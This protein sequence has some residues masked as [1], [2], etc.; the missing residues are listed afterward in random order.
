[1]ER[2]RGGEVE[3]WRGGDCLL[4][5]VLKYPGT[6]TLYGKTL[7]LCSMRVYVQKQTHQLLALSPK[8]YIHEKAH[9][10]IVEAGRVDKTI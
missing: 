7:Q 2:W 8:K 10:V 4:P 1:M 9:V 6:D 5:A 3:R